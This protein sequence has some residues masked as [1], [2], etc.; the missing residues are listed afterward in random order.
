MRQRLSF[1]ISA[2][3][4]PKILLIDEALAV[5]DHRFKAKCHAILNELRSEASTVVLA[6]HSMPEIRR[7]CTR[8]I[9]LDHGEIRLAGDPGEVTEQYVEQMERHS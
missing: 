7:T 2:L 8:V 5:G 3:A 6:S 1:A 4:R 9:W